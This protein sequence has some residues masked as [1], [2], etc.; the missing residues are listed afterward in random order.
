VT[1]LVNLFL[2]FA[3]KPSL[4]SMIGGVAVRHAKGLPWQSA[5]GK[6]AS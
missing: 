3:V 5:Q 2:R 6:M 4:F 1:C